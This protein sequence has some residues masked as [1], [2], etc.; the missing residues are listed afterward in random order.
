MNV[1]L[2]SPLNGCPYRSGQSSRRRGSRYACCPV[3][4]DARAQVWM[5]ICLPLVCLLAHAVDYMA[6]AE[7]RRWGHFARGAFRVGEYAA[8]LSAEHLEHAQVV[9]GARSA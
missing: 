8:P 6:D 4:E 1:I 3:P 2:V 7:R 5:R 9:P